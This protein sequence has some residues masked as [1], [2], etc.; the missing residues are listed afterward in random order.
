M[1]TKTIKQSATFN[2]SP[3]KVYQLIM[4]QKKHAAFSGADV[5]MS[6]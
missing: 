6:K 4:D 5:V 2:A 1:K 3:D